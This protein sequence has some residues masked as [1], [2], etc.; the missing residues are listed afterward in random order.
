MKMYKWLEELGY[1]V[2]IVI[3]YMGKFQEDLDNWR[4]IPIVDINLY[5]KTDHIEFKEMNKKFDVY[6]V[7]FK[8]NEIQMIKRLIRTVKD[9]I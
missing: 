5:D 9:N 7:V 1:E 2:C 8:K 3:S 4:C 6:N